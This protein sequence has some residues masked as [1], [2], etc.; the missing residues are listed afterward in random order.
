LSLRIQPTQHNPAFKKR[1]E[2]KKVSDYEEFKAAFS[3]GGGGGGAGQRGPAAGPHDSRRFFTQHQ[4]HGDTVIV[5]E[6]GMKL[7]V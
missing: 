5:A 4:I 7:P 2:E 3:G 1:A 6:I